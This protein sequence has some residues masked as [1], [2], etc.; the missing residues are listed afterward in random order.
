M[1]VTLK[2]IDGPEAGRVFS[3]TKPDVFLI[4]RIK[5][6][7]IC[8]NKDPY[9]SR[10]QCLIEIS[11]PRCLITNLSDKNPTLVN[12]ETFDTVTLRSGDIVE[13][14]YSRF[15]ISISDDIFSRRVICE[16]C[17]REMELMP[18]EEGMSMCPACMYENMIRSDTPSPDEMLQ[19]TCVCGRDLTLEANSDGR[20]QELEGTVQYACD[21]CLPFSGPEA[22]HTFE[23]YRVIKKLGKGGMGSVYLV[24]QP[25]TCRI[26]VLKLITNLTNLPMIKRF[27]REIFLLQRLH[28]D[29]LVRYV[30]SSLGKEEPYL[31]MSFASEGNL[32]RPMYKQGPFPVHEAVNIIIDVLDGL[33]YIHAQGIVHRDIKPEN[34][35]LHEANGT[36][37]AQITDFGIAKKFTEAGGT[38]LTNSNFTM[39]SPFF[40]PP[41][42]IVNFKDVR[43]P[44]D[45]FSTGITLYYMLTGKLPINYPSPLEARNYIIE[46]NIESTNYNNVIRE[47]GFSGNPCLAML[48]QEL[49]P[50]KE[51]MPN[52]PDSLASVVDKSIRKEVSERYQ[53][54]GEFRTELLHSMSDVSI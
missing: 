35:L 6:A 51:R 39:G 36:V 30:E 47:M 50:I 26:L 19:I 25:A 4:G 27:Q 34:I 20:A 7:H 41:E 31:L 3:F 33:I 18:D 48:I 42:Q 8:I 38:I 37:S 5:D 15:Q 16:T 45:V 11:P 29:H 24:Y 53:S 9:V 2:L 22:G 10:R 40:M 49:I 43:E 52:I 28:H 12:N 44:G 17:S 13:V 23:S 32:N 46:N 54:A 14:G 1:D 21:Q